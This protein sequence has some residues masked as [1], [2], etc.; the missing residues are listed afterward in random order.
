MKR[1]LPLLAAVLLL[2]P[3]G[4]SAPRPQDQTPDQVRIQ[5]TD[6]YYSEV[7]ESG[8]FKLGDTFIKPP[9]LWKSYEFQVDRIPLAARLKMEIYHPGSTEP[10]RVLVNGVEAGVL[11]PCWADLSSP[12]Y[13]I[14]FFDR[15]DGYSQ[16]LDYKDWTGADCWISPDLLKLGE[17][18]LLIFTARAG[19]NQADDVEMR[20][21]EIEFRY[22]G[23][24]CLVTDLR[25][26][27][28]SLPLPYIDRP[29]PGYGHHPPVSERLV[30]F[31]AAGPDE[32]MSLEGMDARTAI[33]I[34]SERVRGGAFSG[35]DDLKK[36]VEGIGPEK[37]EIWARTSYFGDPEGEPTA[38]GLEAGVIRELKEIRKLV[39]GKPARAP[40]AVCGVPDGDD[41]RGPDREALEKIKLPE[42][43]T[44]DQVRQYVEAIREAS[45]DQRRWSTSDPQVEMLTRLGP[46]NF[47]IILESVR[48]DTRNT[49]HLREVLERLARPEHKELVLEALPEIEALVEVVIDNNWLEDARETLIERVRARPDYLPIKW[50]KAVASF[51]DPETYDDL[52][53][54]FVFCNMPSMVHPVLKEIPELEL[55]EAV[56][57]AWQRAKFGHTGMVTMM[58]PIAIEYG[59]PDA[60]E[61]AVRDIDETSGI[62]VFNARDLVLKFT[63]ARGSNEEIRKWYEENKDR[64]VF[65][66]DR[67]RFVVGEEEP[68]GDDV[69]EPEPE[70]VA[71]PETPLPEKGEESGNDNGEAPEPET[72]VLT[73]IGKQN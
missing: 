17:N 56:E 70:A 45:R 11:S 18:K 7:L 59:Y 54:Y 32:L 42:N 5:T 29:D 12:D 71:E 33:R 24:D 52:V 27:S 40:A 57:R 6:E 26:Q 37:I 48:R 66:P 10:A 65:D 60:L 68:A 38:T 55:D 39:E 14:F 9:V 61:Q 25:R 2:L 63:D 51:K 15:D 28:R 64:L 16:A 4:C 46:D 8:P 47:P 13:E 19:T 44:P 43:P 20:N 30:N 21:V 22:L 41:P 1:S 3:A 35:R 62:R 34:F 23:R 69:E 31:N 49:F 72:A 53:E 50:V 36:R 73:P 67:R 58:V